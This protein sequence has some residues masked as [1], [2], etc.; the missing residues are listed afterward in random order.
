MDCKTR[1]KLVAEL[2]TAEPERKYWERLERVFRGFREFSG[3]VKVEGEGAIL[4]LQEVEGELK[5]LL[6]YPEL[7][8]KSI[9]PVGGGFSSGKS[10]FISSFLTRLKLP[11]RI[12]PTTAIAT[13]IVDGERDRAIACNYTGGKV[14]LLEIDGDFLNHLSHQFFNEFQF[15]LKRILSYLVVATPIERYKNIC[16]VDTPGYNSANRGSFEGDTLISREVLNQ[17]DSL[18][19]LIGVDSTGTIPATDLEFLESLELE[20]KRLY[21]VMNKGDLRSGE[22]LEEILDEVE[23]QLEES[24]V[25]FEGI[26]GYSSILREE[27]CFRRKSLF[28][29]LE[30]EN[31]ERLRL[32]KI[33]EKLQWVYLFYKIG[34][35]KEREEKRAILERLKILEMDLFQEGVEVEGLWE[36]KNYFQFNGEGL[37]RELEELFR[38]LEGELGAIFQGEVDLKVEQF[39]NLEVDILKGVKEQVE[40][41]LERERGG[42]GEVEGW[43]EEWDE[44]ERSF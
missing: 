27:Y 34:L 22:E 3:K 36:L 35:L 15:N 7:V 24:G 44:L 1:E 18:I 43:L 30:E 32:G 42:K 12:D 37:L 9:L 10:E 39:S 31:R 29:F 28:Q 11:S 21:I 38:R 33:V 19:W 4:K 13:Y 26:S 14:D 41:W 2:I 6:S 25:E 5:L 23:E 8:K 20:G 40:E 17:S 16:F